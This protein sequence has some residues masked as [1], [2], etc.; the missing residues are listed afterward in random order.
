MKEKIYHC[1]RFPGLTLTVVPFGLKDEHGNKKPAK[2]LQFKD[3]LYLGAGI[4]RVKDESMQK[5]VEQDEYFK[6]G[7]IK[8]VTEDVAHATL[9]PM[10]SNKPDVQLGAHDSSENKSEEQPSAKR[11]IKAARVPK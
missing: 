9:V 11:A 10:K 7:K 4:L 2:H 8:D 5:F 1:G 3:D 6:C